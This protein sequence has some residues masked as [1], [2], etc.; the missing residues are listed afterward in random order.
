MDGASFRF[1]LQDSLLESC[2][3][4]IGELILGVKI[5]FTNHIIKASIASKARLFGF[6]T[7]RFASHLLGTIFARLRRAK[8]TI[9]HIEKTA[10]LWRPF[11]DSLLGA[12]KA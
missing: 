1:S 12:N 7:V 6:R 11:L 5:Y 8:I 9:L 4:N 2:G 3:R 10:P